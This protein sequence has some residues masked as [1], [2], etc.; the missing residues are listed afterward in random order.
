MDKPRL[1]KKYTFYLNESG[2]SFDAPT[3]RHYGYSS[4]M[5]TGGNRCGGGRHG[6]VWRWSE[7]EVT[8][9]ANML[10]QANPWHTAGRH[11]H[12]VT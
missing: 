4:S 2:K 7:P 8:V 12:A 9:Q 3:S 5:V 1:Y 11:Q 6:K 10:W